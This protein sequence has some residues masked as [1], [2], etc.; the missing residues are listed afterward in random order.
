MNDDREYLGR[1][2]PE[3]KVAI[4]IDM[5][6]V[7]MQTC[8]AGI[9]AINPSLSDEGVVEKLWERLDWRKRPRK[10]RR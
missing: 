7:C 3:E 6:D 2:K 9:R 4:C 1:L 8:A 5:T 10:R